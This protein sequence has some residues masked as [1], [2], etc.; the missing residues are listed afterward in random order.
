MKALRLAGGRV[1]G[2]AAR[3]S[4]GDGRGLRPHSGL[5][6]G[7]TLDSQSLRVGALHVD[8]NGLVEVRERF[9]RAAQ[10]PPE[11]P[12]R[13]DLRLQVQQYDLA[14]RIINAASQLAELQRFTADRKLAAEEAGGVERARRQLERDQHFVRG[15]KQGAA[16][17][18][19]ILTDTLERFDR[20][21]HQ[22][23]EL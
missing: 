8:L 22:A 1:A 3:R 2:G 21:I 6:R 4:G 9:Q 7:R 23:Q 11:L 17:T 15:M 16:D 20:A 12:R 19:K 18:A 14:Y 5:P 10:V 13:P